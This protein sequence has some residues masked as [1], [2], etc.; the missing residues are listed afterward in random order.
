MLSLEAEPEAMAATLRAEVSGLLAD[1]LGREESSAGVSSIPAL[2]NLR[3]IRTA[4]P[5]SDGE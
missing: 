1:E 5:E 2:P 3:I 4:E